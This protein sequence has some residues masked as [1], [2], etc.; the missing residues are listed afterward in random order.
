MAI[1]IR[2]DSQIDGDVFGLTDVLEDIGERQILSA[3]IAFLI[4]EN[5]ALRQIADDLG[6]Q[7]KATQPRRE[8]N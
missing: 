2:N 3:Q 7:T 6:W 1:M 5:K 4:D 8:T